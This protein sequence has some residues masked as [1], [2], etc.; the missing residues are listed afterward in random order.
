MSYGVRTFAVLPK[1]LALLE[2]Y[3]NF[4]RGEELGESAAAGWEVEVIVEPGEVIGVGGSDA[5]GLKGWQTLI[6]KIDA[7]GEV[8]EVGEGK[9]GWDGEGERGKREIRGD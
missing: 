3:S 4:H 2:R 5:G 9:Q 7:W 6:G 8:G 1:G